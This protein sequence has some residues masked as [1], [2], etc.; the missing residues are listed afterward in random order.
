MRNST[1]QPHADQ[2]I[3]H[4]GHSR[5][6]REDDMHLPHDRDESVGATGGEPDLRVAQAHQ[7]LQRGLRDTDRGPVADRTYRRLKNG[8]AGA[9]GAASAPSPSVNSGRGA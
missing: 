3:A 8:V 1:E 7:D 6:G 5:R 9:G 2:A 4:T